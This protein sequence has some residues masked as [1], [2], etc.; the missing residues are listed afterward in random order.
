MK[1]GSIV[2]N[3]IVTILCVGAAAAAF[4]FFWRDLNGTLTKLDEKPV[5]MVVVKDKVVQRHFSDR[6]VW[7]QLRT[8]SPVYQG[9]VIRTADLSG[10][11]MIFINDDS[12]SMGENTM[13]QLFYG[14]QGLEVNI[15]SGSV[16]AQSGGGQDLVLISG[17]NRVEVAPGGAV[18]ANTAA[19]GV[20]ALQVMEGR[21]MLASGGTRE[22]VRAGDVFAVSAS[23]EV[24]AAPRVV[25]LE[26]SDGAAVVLGSGDF[27]LEQNFRWNPVN[28]DPEETVRLEIAHDRRF[29]QIAGS[30]DARG[31]DREVFRLPAGTYWWRAYPVS[32][33]GAEQFA[34]VN[35][36]V[37]EPEEIAASG[38][39]AALDNEAQQSIA[40]ESERAE[41]AA[42]PETENA[43]T[44]VLS[45]TEHA[46]ASARPEA[47]LAEPEAAP[48]LNG[49]AAPE[50]SGGG[51][52]PP[53]ITS[54]V[55]LS[56]AAGNFVE[57]GRTAPALRWTSQSP[58]DR[59]RV[60]IWR[61][62]EGRPTLGLLEA[63]ASSGWEVILPGLAAG[64][65]RWTVEGRTLEGD[66]ISA[67]GSSEFR[68]APIPPLSAPGNLRPVRNTRIG[69]AEILN[70]R[71]LTLSWNAVSGAN[72][73]V[74]TI[75]TAD[76]ELFVQ[77]P[78]QRALRYVIPD[79][80]ALG[81][82]TV[83][84]QVEALS[85]SDNNTVRRLG[86]PAQSS[87][88][89]TVRAPQSTELVE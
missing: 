5:A 44:S 32:E 18:T 70:S 81:A 15:S 4:W 49:G 58:I 56:Q 80:I 19:G 51:E 82:G 29:T 52:A 43:E 30:V 8:D 45:E 66:D 28:L 31:T 65:Y 62:D 84:W 71:S 17:E 10:V 59:L 38:E 72:A 41:T 26:P 85:L 53:R 75:R 27:P 7:D 46:E 42:R 60:I 2:S 83:N 73:Y 64:N 1:T 69:R 50:S 77:T 48:I 47:A 36:F 79:V 23:G 86:P 68:V 87:F 89:T 74:V 55:V 12:V 78:P 39:L 3:S 37:L 34:A 67:V 61:E 35:R 63:G 9:D 6:L 20:F 88:V 22:M 21:V 11:M 13:I 25:L 24:R 14:E 76:Q 40:G 57:G 33:S 54:P 16:T